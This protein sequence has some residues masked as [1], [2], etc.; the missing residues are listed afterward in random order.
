MMTTVTVNWPEALLGGQLE[1]SL[2]AA[3]GGVGCASLSAAPTD[4]A[5][6]G[7]DRPRPPAPEVEGQA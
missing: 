4:S 5:E 1:P 7:A 3:R 6:A 2:P